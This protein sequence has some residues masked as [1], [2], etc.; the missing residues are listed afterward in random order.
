MLLFTIKSQ[1]PKLKRYDPDKSQCIELI[2]FYEI[3]GR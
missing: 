1:I 3:R 2:D